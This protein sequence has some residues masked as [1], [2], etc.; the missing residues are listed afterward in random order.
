MTGRQVGSGNSSCLWRYLRFP[1]PGIAP[2]G[3]YV[4]IGGA[5][6]V[7]EVWSE[8]MLRTYG[9]HIVWINRRPKDQVVQA[10]LDR[11]AGLGSA[12][13]YMSADATDEVALR[14]AYEDIK[15]RYGQINGVVHAAVVLLD[16]SLVHM[17]EARF[18]AG[19]AAKVDTSVQMARVFQGEPLDFVLFFSSIMTFLKPPGQANYAAGCTFQ[20]AFAHQ[21]GREWSRPQG[22]PV[23]KVMHWG[24]WGSVGVAASETYRERMA[25]AGLGSHRPV[26]GDGRSRSPARWTV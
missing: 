26:K 13:H 16:Q 1:V 9:A 11:L 17:D 21:L 8:Y 4:V 19:L 14:R 5:G 2:G 18:L 23:V 15:A 20:D 25:K 10:K 7:G 3:V 12:P 6:G 24:Y 22:G